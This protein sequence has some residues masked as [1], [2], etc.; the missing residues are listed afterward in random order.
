M[1][2]VAHARLLLLFELVMFDVTGEEREEG[3]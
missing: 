2:W 3:A 1:H